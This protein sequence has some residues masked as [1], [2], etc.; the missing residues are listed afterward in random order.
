[1]ADNR[2]PG[3]AGQGGMQ[4]PA[5]FNP[6]ANMGMG[7]MGQPMFGGVGQ[8]QFAPGMAFYP[9]QGMNPAMMGLMP[10]MAP[11]MMPMQGMRQ[12]VG[13]PPAYSQ[14]MASS[15]HNKT[16][17][18]SGTKGGMGGP[19][20]PKTEK[21]RYFEEQQKR[22]RHFNKPGAHVTDANTLVDNLFGKSEKHGPGQGHGQKHGHGHRPGSDHHHHHSHPSHAAPAQQNTQPDE[23]DGFGDFLGGPASAS[24]PAPAKDPTVNTTKNTQPPPAAVSP[25]PQASAEESQPDPAVIASK[26]AVEKKDLVSMMMEC[27]DLNAPQKARGFHK[28]SLMEVQKSGSHHHGHHSAKHAE[29]HHASDHARRWDNSQELDGLFIVESKPAASPQPANLPPQSP[30]ATSVPQTFHHPSHPEMMA[31]PP[32]VP[33]QHAAQLAGAPGLSGVPE[34]GDG[35]RRLSEVSRGLPD[36]CQD[37]GQNLPVLYQ[38]VLEAVL[39]GE[40]IVTE[41]VY[42]ILILS[43]LPRELLGRLWNLANTQTPGQL[44]RSELWMLLAFIALV[45]NKYEVTSPVILK[46]CPL[47][48]VPFLGQQAPSAAAPTHNA[49]APANA[50]PTGPDV[51]TDHIGDPAN[52]AH[53]AHAPVSPQ[54]FPPTFQP[55]PPSAAAATAVLATGTTEDDFADF[56][57]APTPAATAPSF[58]PPPAA[59][60]ASVPITKTEDSYGEFIGGQTS[61]ASDQSL[62]SVPKEAA[63]RLEKMY[64]NGGLTADE[65]YNSNVRNFFC[66][67][68]S[69][70]E[71][72]PAS[73]KTRHTT[74]N[75]LDDEDFT[76][77]HDSMS[78]F[79]TSEQSENEDI[80]AFENYVEEFNRKK[81]AQIPA[82]PLRTG[83]NQGAVKVPHKSAAGGK[84][85][86][87]SA[88]PVAV[89]T[90]PVV[91]IPIPKLSASGTTIPTLP[92]GTGP[93]IPALPPVSSGLNLSAKPGAGGDDDDFD[94]F[95]SAAGTGGSIKAADAGIAKKAASGDMVL[96]GDEDKYGALRSL[97]E[98]TASLFE[99]KEE[100]E[101]GEDDDEWADFSTAADSGSK[102][103][104][105]LSVKG[106]H[107]VHNPTPSGPLGTDSGGDWADFAAPGGTDGNPPAGLSST[108]AALSQFPSLPDSHSSSFTAFGQES[109]L[110]SGSGKAEDSGDD[111]A[112]FSSAKPDDA[113]AFSKPSDW[114]AGSDMHPSNTDNLSAFGNAESG[115]G[116]GLLSSADPTTTA[117]ASSDVFTG[118]DQ[119]AVLTVKKKNLGTTEIMNV[120]KVRDDPATLSSYH[121]PKQPADPHASSQKQHH[122]QEP[123]SRSRRS[124]SGSKDHQM[125]PDLDGDFHMGPP[126]LDSVGDDD[127]E[128]EFSRGYDLDDI[129]N[130]PVPTTVY[131]P[132]GYAHHAPGYTKSAF[133]AVTKTSKA[134]SLP[135]PS[136]ESRSH[137]MS[138]DSGET[139]SLSNRV[140][141]LREDSQSVSSL[142]LPASKIS[143]VDAQLD[144]DN[145]GTDS[146]SVSSMEFGA[147]TGGLRVEGGVSESKSLDSLDLHST[148]AEEEMV[149]ESGGVGGNSGHPPT[150][151]IQVGSAP[152]LGDRYNLDGQVSEGSE[153]YAYEWER[154]LASSCRHMNNANNV[155]NTISSS[156]VCNE[157][158]KSPHG[159]DYIL[160]LI[161]VY[162]VVRRIMTALPTT[163]VSSAS[164]EQSLKQMDLAWNNLTA[165]LVGA[166]LL[167]DEA[168]MTFTHAILKTDIPAAQQKACGVCLLDVDSTSRN[169]SGEETPKLAYG[170]RQYHAPCANF[171]V[172]CVDSMLPAL[173]LP[174]LL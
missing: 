133:T 95:K 120:F 119:S 147:T 163:A 11:N 112:D 32:G 40:T 74:P 162:R 67:S 100:G 111:W 143:S 43:G 107:S 130:Q 134:S 76:D 5:G 88:K 138:P 6:M 68:D 97:V 85:G 131:S 157:V 36:W 122:H 29:L 50:V 42:P 127:D 98:N 121:L 83:K 116:G 14:R 49:P 114:Q 16:R 118:T 31:H 145:G 91:N 90:P 47:A 37:S 73:K 115:V 51:P 103:S 86:A 167:P 33:P 28:P 171:W 104:S 165:F 84:S 126:P 78:Q 99:K 38:Q 56:Q 60:A 19:P 66:S 96:I 45:Q 159:S 53:N 70:T 156:S 46:R 82:N 44:I 61:S 148:E 71:N 135:T 101:G 169:S 110:Q 124:C 2:L 25:S 39:D 137:S 172:N 151:V 81:E 18:P 55:P 152:I 168:T 65:Q 140:A 15:F 108:N 7:P 155:F 174:E 48:P 150:G 123:S 153:R 4:Q 87:S 9:P 52:L 170:G 54:P 58:P 166:S 34:G 132:F 129:V 160:G 161:E 80:R 77:G 142:D 106:V 139:D 10:G 41:R 144:S 20:K 154:C 17:M 21:E 146:Q 105:E 93:A 164:I 92:S 89:K 13:P 75:S 117:A 158:L 102:A 22:L 149:E 35:S 94:D 79:S 8:Q 64:S 173:K 59:V 128:H 27:S 109:S 24:A 23:D 69:S 62:S 57:A 72:S 136:A 63:E 113:S 1:M 26:Q 12:P 3:M 125:S 141:S 30:T